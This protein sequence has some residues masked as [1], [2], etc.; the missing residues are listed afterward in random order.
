M[1]RRIS[2]G[3]P[4]SMYCNKDVFVC[5]NQDKCKDFDIKCDGCKHN[6]IINKQSFF[7]PINN[8]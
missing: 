2:D 4:P 3:V 8:L 1:N 7:E 5:K 6:E